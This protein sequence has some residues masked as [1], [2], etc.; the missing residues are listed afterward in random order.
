[1]TPQ[2][3]TTLGQLLQAVEALRRLGVRSLPMKAAYHLTKLRRLIDS[4]L[5]IFHERRDALLKELGE[6][7][8]A[9]EAELKAGTPATMFEIPPSQMATFG[10]RV[11]ELTEL[12]VTIPW[13]P[14]DLR[15]LG[16]DAE[17]TSDDLY[18]LR[19]GEP[20]AL[21]T[22]DETSRVLAMP[23]HTKRQGKKSI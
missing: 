5:T 9:T 22:A 7:R 2:I 15:S 17:L 12:E 19:F 23:T 1:M 4:E 11:K 16:D 3:Q 6:Q 8:P 18:A 14:F 13:G 20:G 21:V 10:T